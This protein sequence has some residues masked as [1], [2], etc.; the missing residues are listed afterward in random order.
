MNVLPFPFILNPYKV[1]TKYTSLCNY[2]TISKNLW[3]Y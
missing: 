3:W 1:M 2:F